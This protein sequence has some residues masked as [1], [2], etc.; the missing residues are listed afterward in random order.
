MQEDANFDLAI[1]ADQAVR[2]EVS[3][4]PLSMPNVKHIAIHD[5]SDVEGRPKRTLDFTNLAFGST[6]TNVAEDVGAAVIMDIDAEPPA[7]AAA[8]SSSSDV[9]SNERADWLNNGPARARRAVVVSTARVAREVR[10][11]AG[12]NVPLIPDD[13]YDDGQNSC[14]S[15][16]TSEGDDDVAFSSFDG[17]VSA[18]GYMAGNGALMP[19]PHLSARAA[20]ANRSGVAPTT[21]PRMAINATDINVQLH[22]LS[23]QG[24]IAIVQGNNDGMMDGDAEDMVDGDSDVEV[25][26]PDIEQIELD[27]YAE[28]PPKQPPPRLPPPEPPP[29]EP[30]PFL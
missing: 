8:R 29:P 19:G 9:P 13:D 16:V 30:D 14:F 7:Q 4:P 12:E 17:T 20:D 26:E 10:A 11:D 3:T 15:D 23:P 27:L 2:A 18:T 1:L 21:G 5:R 28:L 25:D 6:T 22:P 24:V